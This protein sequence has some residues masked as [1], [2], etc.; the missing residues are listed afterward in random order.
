MTISIIDAIIII[1]GIVIVSII[2]VAYSKYSNS[3]EGFFVAGRK[4]NYPLV[5]ASML[6]SWHGI[7]FYLWLPGAVYT[8]GW[9]GWLVTCGMYCVV[10]MLMG[11]FFAYRARAVGQYTVPDLYGKAYGEKT[12]LTGGIAYFLYMAVYASQQIVACGL[13]LNFVFGMNKNLAVILSAAFVVVYCFTAGQYAV[14]ITDFIQYI[15][16]AVGLALLCFF[17]FGP[18]LQGGNGVLISNLQAVWTNPA[19]FTGAST[20]SLTQIIGFSV[21]GIEAIMSP[22]YYSRAFSAKDAKTARNGI[23]SSLYAMISHDWMLMVI[24]IGSVVVLGTSL[25]DQ[26]EQATLYLA[27][28]V[29]PVGVSGIVFAALIAAG[30][31]TINSAFIAGASNLGRDV[32][33]KFINPKATQKQIVN[34]GRIGIVVEAA[35]TVVVAVNADSLVQLVYTIG[36]IAM[37]VFIIPIIGIFFSKKSKTSMQFYLSMI[38]GLIASLIW[39]F[40]GEPD[41]IIPMPAGLFGLICAAIGYFIGGRFGKKHESIWDEIYSVK[42]IEKA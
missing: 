29:L 37:P 42:K 31:S 33:Q 27:S 9:G 32:Y 25:A 18:I 26:S 39:L 21:I 14:F 5:V 11:Y 23:L 36:Q 13:V 41:L 19:Q 2:G 16:M 3:V 30:L 20:Y 6:A 34:I 22:L 17:T 4:M 38:F 7:A 1:A 28:H 10:D 40:L 35:L 8:M 15:F 12:Q 24:G